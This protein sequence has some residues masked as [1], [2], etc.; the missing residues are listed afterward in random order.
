MNKTLLAA[1]VAL[2]ASAAFAQ[3]Q[4][5][6]V[7]IPRDSS[8]GIPIAIPEMTP[9]GNPDRKDPQVRREIDAYTALVTTAVANTSLFEVLERERSNEI[10]NEVSFQLLNPGARMDA[11]TDVNLRGAR[12][13]LICG[14]GKLYDRIVITSRLVDLRTG[15]IL[16]ANTIYAAEEQ[17]ASAI[18]E[19]AASIKEKGFELNK[20]V[21]KADIDRLVKARNWTEAKRSIDIY[22]RTAKADDEVRA[23]YDRIAVGLSETYYAQSKKYVTQRLFKEARLRID[24]AIALKPDGRYYAWRERIAEVE[25][26]W[27][28][29]KRIEMA[30]REAELDKGVYRPGFW[31]QV[32]EDL[33]TVTVEGTRLAATYS[34]DVDQADFSVGLPGGD[35]GAEF[36]WQIPRAPKGGKGVV[37]WVAYLGAALRYE[38]LASGGMSLFAQGYLSPLAAESFKVGPFVLSVGVDGGGAV[39]LGGV[40]DRGYIAGGTLGGLVALETKFKG[41][42]GFFTALKGDYRWYPNDMDHSAYCLRLM[43]GWT[44]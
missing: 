15:R 19:L 9:F 35:F 25:V 10:L 6:S 29:R 14:F 4:S 30:R 43:A 20:T 18:N 7:G 41:R 17:L 1:L 40:S 32:S 27:E 33:E 39:Q 11:S 2:A 23:A 26:E 38:E 22:L 24:E 44:F 37:N 34:L 5:E 21:T 13:I 28:Y 8:V 12:A 3:T 16:F 42:T 36:S 31:R